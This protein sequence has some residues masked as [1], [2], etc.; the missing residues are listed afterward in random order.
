[1]YDEPFVS[2]HDGIMDSYKQL[3]NG[4]GYWWKEWINETFIKVLRIKMNDMLELDRD[5]S[6]FHV[7]CLGQRNLATTFME[8][9]EHT[10]F[11]PMSDINDEFSFRLFKWEDLDWVICSVPIA[12]AN[13][14]Y[15]AASAVGCR[16]AN[17]VP[18]II[19]IANTGKGVVNTRESLEGE[20]PFGL[21]GVTETVFPL[22]NER[23]FTLEPD[24]QRPGPVLGG[25]GNF[26]PA[27]ARKP[28]QEPDLLD[29]ITARRKR[30]R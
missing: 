7:I 18:H 5:E 21:K 26:R 9:L 17:G 22:N 13:T 24:H 20:L 2:T 25:M 4:E 16:L 3:P 29:I 6:Q 12:K 23:T 30:K 19:G 11:P 14:C 8:H 15:L 27:P 1:M 28:P 10:Y